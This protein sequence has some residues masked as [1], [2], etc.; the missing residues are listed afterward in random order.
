MVSQPL[1]TQR[2]YTQWSQDTPPLETPGTLSQQISPSLPW[3]FLLSFL[4]S[5][6]TNFLPLFLLVL[7]PP[8]MDQQYTVLFLSLF[9]PS[10]D[11]PLLPFYVTLYSQLRIACFVGPWSTT[12]LSNYVDSMAMGAFA[13]AWRGGMVLEEATDCMGTWRLVQRELLW[14]EGLL[15]VR[16]ERARV[17][18]GGVMMAGAVGHLHGREE[19][20]VGAC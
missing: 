14:W 11:Q 7:F 4:T 15:H 17:A 20:A 13:G 2:K 10:K 18:A 19:E 8:E 5:K 6:V 16:L 12:D 3:Y 9:Q 1:K